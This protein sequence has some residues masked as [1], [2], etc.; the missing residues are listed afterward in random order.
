MTNWEKSQI[1]DRLRANVGEWIN[2]HGEV[3]FENSRSN[4]YVGMTIKKIK[5]QDRI[6]QDYMGRRRNMRIRKSIGKRNRR[7]AAFSFEIYSCNMYKSKVCILCSNCIDIIS[8][9]S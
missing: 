6:Y 4:E 9:Q 2:S 5:W 7:W 8:V 1:A 3:I